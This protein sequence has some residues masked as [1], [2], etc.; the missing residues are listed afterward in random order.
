M[1]LSFVLI[2]SRATAWAPTGR[3]PLRSGEAFFPPQ[4]QGRGRRWRHFFVGQQQPSQEA[5][6]ESAELTAVASALG[7]DLE[8]RGGQCWA[9][10]PFHD[11]RTPSFKLDDER[12]TY[13]CFGCGAKGGT[14]QLAQQLMGGSYEEAEAWLGSQQSEVLKHRRR[15]RLFA[16]SR[17]KVSREVGVS[18]MR[19]AVAASAAYYASMLATSLEAGGARRYLRERGISPK[20]AAAFGLGFSPRREGALAWVPASPAALVAAGVAYSETEPLRDRF[21][22]RLMLP[23]RDATGRPLGFGS[24]ALPDDDDDEEDDTRK[25]RFKKRK[26]VNSPSTDIFAKSAVL[27]GLDVAA[28]EIRKKDEAVV[29]EGYFDVLALQEAGIGHVVGALGVGLGPKQIEQAACFCD[30]R[31][32]VILLDADDAAKNALDKLVTSV[33]PDLVNTK[34]LDVYIASLP[35]G[36]KDSAEFVLGAQQRITNNSTSKGKGKKTTNP[37][38]DEF[39]RDVLDAAILWSHRQKSTLLGDVFAPGTKDD[40]KITDDDTTSLPAL[41]NGGGGHDT[42]LEEENLSS[43]EDRRMTFKEEWSFYIDDDIPILH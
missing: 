35:P 9:R 10:C 15:P 11:E 34:G 21:A 26:Y 38:A 2:M 23:I 7:L 25:R 22:G 42:A 20:T 18:E 30:S 43:S 1:L 12:G 33:L 14:I 8:Y 16:S 5:Q 27:Y 19:R 31:R 17:E 3:M 36:Y 32:V 29:V 6:L 28:R 41:V 24:R 13:Y 37:I 39:Q 4:R 40:N